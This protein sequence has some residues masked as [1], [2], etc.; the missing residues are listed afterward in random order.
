M[1]SEL[2]FQD[3]AQFIVPFKWMNAFELNWPHSKTS[4]I[5]IFKVK[6]FCSYLQLVWYVIKTT[7][8]IPTVLRLNY[9][10]SVSAHFNYT[11]CCYLNRNEIGKAFSVHFWML[12]DFSSF[13]SRLSSSLQFV[14]HCRLKKKMSCPLVSVFKDTHRK[15]HFQIKVFLSH[16][17]LPEVSAN[18]PQMFLLRKILH[19]LS[20]DILNCSDSKSVLVFRRNCRRNIWNEENTG[21]SWATERASSEQSRSLQHER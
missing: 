3:C 4:W 11:I 20:E 9:F 14:F 17:F 5:G 7:I 16:L 21:V 10:I 12:T 19:R 18:A 15:E 6:W 1:T 13:V 2:I 8:I